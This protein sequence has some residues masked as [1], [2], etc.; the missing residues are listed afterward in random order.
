MSEKA[1]TLNELR[2]RGID[3]LRRELGT[4]GMIRFIQQFDSGRGDYTE[5][6]KDLLDDVDLGTILAE[7][8]E[9]RAKQPT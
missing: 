6:R 3:A 7:I 9:R 2:V 1:T 4:V 8:R 5:D